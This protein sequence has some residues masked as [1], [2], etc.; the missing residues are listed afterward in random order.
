M[1]IV[2]PTYGRSEVFE[3]AIQ[4]ARSAGTATLSLLSNAKPNATELLLGVAAVF[5]GTR[6]VPL[7]S[8]HDPSRSAADD[9]LDEMARG[10]SLALV[11]IAD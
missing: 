11:A 8:K 5:A 7:F 3:A 1:R 9:L 4:K 2:N 6:D 10:G